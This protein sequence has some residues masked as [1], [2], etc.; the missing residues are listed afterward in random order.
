MNDWFFQQ[1]FTGGTRA[2]TVTVGEYCNVPADHHIH[3]CLSCDKDWPCA[4]THYRTDEAT[5]KRV[6]DTPPRATK[7]CPE[8]RGLGF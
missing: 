2:S 3:L 5:Q 6:P 8:C 7:R 1:G 4:E